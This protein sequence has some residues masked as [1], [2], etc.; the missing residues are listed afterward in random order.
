MITDEIAEFLESGLSVAVATRD[1]RLAPA[2]M[3]AMG[4]RVHEDRRH[5]DLFLPVVTAERTRRDLERVGEV[6]ASF[7]RPATHQTLQLKGTV[8]ALREAGEADR[9]VVE[10]YRLAM[11]ESFEAAGVPARRTARI[12]YWPCLVLELGVREIF[13]Q[14]PG[15]GAG[16]RLEPGAGE[17]P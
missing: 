4:V 9:A 10:R 11:I 13:H 5:I 8:V 14:T 2:C 12:A 15:P 7:S 1:P 16:A 3:R 17:R 6:A